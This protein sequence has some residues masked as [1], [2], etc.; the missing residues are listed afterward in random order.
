MSELASVAAWFACVFC[1]IFT[2]R[3]A[4]AFAL[5]E[6]GIFLALCVYAAQ[7]AVL[8]VYYTDPTRPNELLPAM[9]GYLSAVAGFLLI[10]QHQLSDPV[11][12]VKPLEQLAAWLLLLIALP[13]LV[14]TP[15]GHELLQGTTENDVIV[16]IILILDTIGFAALYK[17]LAVSYPSK[18]KR[19]FLAVP[20]S[21]YW[22]LNIMFAVVTLYRRVAGVG[23][24]IEMSDG[25]RYA[26][27]IVKVITVVTFV[28]AVLAPYEP[29][30]SSSWSK[31]SLV[32]VHLA[33]GE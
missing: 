11:V 9:S 16:A 1:V 22:G 21:V 26:F 19:F 3:C 12:S 15:F 27:A 4:F 7:W 17:V 29:F 5:N 18:L 30:K 24:T 13:K 25:F 6:S 31:R 33:G 8:I 14:P 23:G 10:R 32:F 28:P 20:M 2:L